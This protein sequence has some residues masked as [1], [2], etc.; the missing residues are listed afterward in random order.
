M[1]RKKEE[2]FKMEKKSTNAG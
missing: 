2:G 1:K